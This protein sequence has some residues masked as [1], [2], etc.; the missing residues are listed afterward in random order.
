MV[1]RRRSPAWLEI[2]PFTS[3]TFAL[4]GGATFT[5]AILNP[6][7]T[8]DGTINFSVSYL[9]SGVPFTQ[10]FHLDGNGQN[11]FGIEAQMGALIT[12]VTFSTPDS[13]FAD[14]SQFRLGGFAPAQAPDGGTT[15]MLLGASLTAVELLRRKL[16]KRS[17]RRLVGRCR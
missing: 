7:A 16:L 3:L 10:T 12:S 17:P 8:V 1:A 2:I 13:S 9:M 15:L 4:E 11:F 6:D 14:A 5:N